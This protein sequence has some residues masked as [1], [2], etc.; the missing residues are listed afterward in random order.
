MYFSIALILG[1][2]YCFELQEYYSQSPC[3][4]LTGITVPYTEGRNVN[5]LNDTDFA[6]GDTIYLAGSVKLNPGE[7]PLKIKDDYTTWIGLDLAGIIDVFP[8]T[9]TEDKCPDKYSPL[10]VSASNVKIKD[11]GFIRFIKGIP[12][13]QHPCTD[14]SRFYPVGIRGDWV[15][16]EGVNVGFLILGGAYDNP[17]KAYAPDDCIKLTGDFGGGGNF[18]TLV[19]SYI[20]SC[21]ESGLDA[22]G[23]DCITV[24]NTWFNDTA[25][26]AIS[27]KGGS[28]NVFLAGNFMWHTEGIQLGG[29]SSSEF[30][31]N[32]SYHVTN[33]Y[34]LNNF[35]F[36]PIKIAGADSVVME[37]NYMDFYEAKGRIIG[38]GPCSASDTLRNGYI[39]NTNAGDINMWHEQWRKNF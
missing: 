32:C 38:E 15:T 12:E 22:V 30:Q 7:K 34:L 19:D 29:N 26:G 39:K 17:I 37:S 8:P 6:Q 2:T 5:D 35:S 13:T 14:Y 31:E 3:D 16:M 24:K 27:I 21:G 33:A 36:D 18:F 1:T 9:I 4:S 10:Q 28:S 25:N 23:E 20:S 11:I